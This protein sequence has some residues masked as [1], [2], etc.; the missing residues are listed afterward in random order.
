[1]QSTFWNAIFQDVSD[2]NSYGLLALYERIDASPTW[3]DAQDMPKRPIQVSHICDAS[4][5]TTVI[6]AALNA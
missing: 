5:E 6:K 2:E 3:Q 4:S 1:M